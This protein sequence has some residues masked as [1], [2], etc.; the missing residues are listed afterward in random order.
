MDRSLQTAGWKM[1]LTQ[2]LLMCGHSASAL[3]LELVRID[4]ELA[5][6]PNCRLA[7]YV[8]H[9]E[10]V[11]SRLCQNIPACKNLDRAW[12]RYSNLG[13]RGEHKLKRSCD[14]PRS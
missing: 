9:V 8:S 7:G 4:S 12:H 6:M 1:E 13:P 14:I 5:H 11:S 10:H 3:V 2:A